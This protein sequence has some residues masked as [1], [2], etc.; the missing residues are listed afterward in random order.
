MEMSDVHIEGVVQ[1]RF[2]AVESP[3]RTYHHPVGCGEPTSGENDRLSDSSA[4]AYKGVAEWRTYPV[5]NRRIMLGMNL[6]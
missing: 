2:A 4:R 3:G 5:P 6:R 1:E